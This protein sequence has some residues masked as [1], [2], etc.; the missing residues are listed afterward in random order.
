MESNDGEMNRNRLLQ[1]L[2]G[3]GWER[4]NPSFITAALTPCVSINSV[5]GWVPGAGS[6]HT[7][8]ETVLI[9]AKHRRD[10]STILMGIIGHVH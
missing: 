9:D 3:P 1:L 2:L 4:K 7:L 10:K 6:L 8:V 5:T